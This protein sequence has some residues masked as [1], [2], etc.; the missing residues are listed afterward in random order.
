MKSLTFSRG[1]R[2]VWIVISC[3]WLVYWVQAFPLKCHYR[4]TLHPQWAGRDIDYYTCMW[5]HWQWY[6]VDLLNGGYDSRGATYYTV[7]DLIAGDF[8]W[9][10]GV[11]VLLVI[12]YWVV[13]WIARGFIRAD[14]LASEEGSGSPDIPG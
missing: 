14:S 7:P 10:I 1:F 11:P 4:I 8:L 13:R 9:A 12:S 2:R 6:Y 5:S 3:V